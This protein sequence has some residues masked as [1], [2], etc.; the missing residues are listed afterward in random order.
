[1]AAVMA[2]NHPAKDLLAGTMPAA[3][4]PVAAVLLPGVVRGFGQ[5]FHCPSLA[6]GLLMLGA[7]AA[8]SP[9]AALIGLAGGLLSSLL[10]PAHPRGAS[11]AVRCR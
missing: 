6:S 9:L 10:T 2:I 5:V 11:V 4:V 7:V 8:G 1:M 3:Q